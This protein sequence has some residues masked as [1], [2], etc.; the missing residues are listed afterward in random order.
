MELRVEGA[1]VESV[2]Y[3]SNSQSF[4]GYR[5]VDFENNNVVFSINLNLHLI[6]K[7]AECFPL[8]WQ[9]GFLKIQYQQ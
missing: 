4:D 6:K 8:L 2:P 9:A 7:L 3:E 1:F 5:F